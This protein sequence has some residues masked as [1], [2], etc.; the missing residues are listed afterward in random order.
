MDP[1]DPGGNEAMMLEEI[2]M[3]PGQF[4]EIM[5]HT[6]PPADRAGKPGTSIRPDRKSKLMRNL[7]GIEDLT[8]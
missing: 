2:E 3:A 1:R 6:H 4:P 8:S 5:G 7:F